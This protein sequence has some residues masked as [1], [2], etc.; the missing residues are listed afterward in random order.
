M[1][2]THQGIASSIVGPI[3]WIDADHGYVNCP[4]ESLH[5][6]KSGRRDCR[7]YLDGAPTV[8]CFHQS[9]LGIVEEINKRLR[10]AIGKQQMPAGQSKVRLTPEQRQRRQQKQSDAALKCRAAMSMKSLV[11]GWPWT[12]A[13]AF[14][15]SPHRLLDDPRNDW[16][17]LLTLFN[18]DDRIWIGA[19]KD[20]GQPRHV[21]NFA[22]PTEHAARIIDGRFTPQFTCPSTFEPGTLSRA[23]DNVVRRP[24]LVIESDHLSK[25]DMTCLFRWCRQFMRLRAIV[26]TGG[27]S[28]HGWFDYPADDVVAELKAILPALRCD[29]ALFKPSQPCR[30][31]GA[32]RDG[33][34]QSLLFFDPRT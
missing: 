7:V 12:P 32:D 20:S 18:P 31:P 14:E 24:Y 4:G 21:A 3:E 2:A 30:L 26:D 23:N 22:T 13:D 6:H 19:V 10:S 11:A 25:T 33:K 8:Y 9:C 5:T 34:T 28:L 29:P 1:S 16:R 27:K 17:L 15:E